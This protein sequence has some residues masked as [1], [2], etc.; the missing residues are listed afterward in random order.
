[1]RTGIAALLAVLLAPA[2]GG[3]L[4]AEPA[5]AA[6]KDDLTFARALVERGWT[7]VAEPVIERGLAGG[8]AEKERFRVLQADLLLK[9]ARRIGG[10]Q[11]RAEAFKRAFVVLDDLL[12]G[13]GKDPGPAG[14]ELGEF[15]VTSCSTV[16]EEARKETEAARAAE[17]KK[18][19]V[20]MVD[21]ASAIFTARLEAAQKSGGAPAK[22]G[23]D[24]EDEQGA[25]SA[26]RE[27]MDAAF[28]AARVEYERGLV[29]D[30]KVEREA[31]LRGAIRKLEDF[32]ASYADTLQAYQSAN[33]VGQCWNELGDFRKAAQ[34]FEGAASLAEQFKDGS[35]Q[36]HVNH[37]V[38]AEIIQRALYFKAQASNRAGKP[39]DARAAVDRAIRLFPEVRKRPIGLALRIEGGQAFAKQAK[40]REAE[41]ALR[42]V[43]QDDPEGP[44]GAQARER[45]GDLI[46]K[47]DSRMEGDL[48]PIIEG[49]FQK[50]EVAR[51]IRILRQ[52]LARFDL[53]GSLDAAAKRDL[54]EKA[55][56]VLMW[57][58]KAYDKSERNREAALVFE[59]LMERYPA[60]KLAPEAAFQSVR[61]R[62]LANAAA[63]SKFDQERYEE[64]LKRLTD[65]YPRSPQA[66]AGQFLKA[67]EAMKAGKFDDAVRLYLAVP[68]TAGQYRDTALYQAGLAAW[69]RAVRTPSLKDAK[70]HYD[71]AEKILKDTL[72]ACTKEEPGQD[73]DRA[74]N[75]ARV[76]V[77]ARVK[78]ADIY[79]SSAIKRF[80]EALQVIDATQKEDSPDPDQVALLNQSRV[81]T[82]SALGRLDDAV[83]A[84]QALRQSHPSTRL[85]ASLCR[86][87]AMAYDNRAAE[88]H[89]AGGDG[90]KDYKPLLSK[91]LEFYA[92]AFDESRRLRAPFPAS[93]QVKTADRAL[94]IALEV[95]GLPEGK[96][97][98]TD[99]LGKPPPPREVWERAVKLLEEA[100]PKQRGSKGTDWLPL[101][102]LGRAY[103]FLGDWVKARAA[104]E[105]ALVWGELLASTGEAEPTPKQAALEK[106]PDLLDIFLDL[107]FAELI[108]AKKGGVGRARAIFD[109]GFDLAQRDTCPWWKCRYGFIASEIKDGNYDKADGLLRIAQNAP[110]WSGPRCGL[111]EQFDALAKELESKVLK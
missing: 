85:L 73:P 5:A 80:P 62:L 23:E 50:N 84:Y 21:A 82:L 83:Q 32:Q 17:L 35:G 33:L 51:A 16:A 49:L 58:G 78:L 19:A 98:F 69:S 93:T 13:A 96:D 52:A 77:A 29:L 74:Q 55:P 46:G 39:A 64:D 22:A 63:S 27:E 36:P 104:L 70:P 31:A 42:E 100:K 101:A 40:Y 54:A 3:G 6:R 76:R 18:R 20:K 25:G 94:A 37:P 1:V 34:A 92:A 91:A 111:K 57:L 53:Q 110:E 38:A 72:A 59:E 75:R 11:P 108:P 2:A 60:H 61:S 89:K 107:G 99:L 9:A 106:A 15:L 95:T 44:G 71:R 4:A 41:A 45:L 47:G 97:S 30:D 81:R 103:G 10:A 26:S 14:V 90:Q 86:E 109:K 28:N 66:A 88:V 43:V 102:K 65:K 56:P 12:A 8:G 105:E 87:V 48:G 68:E 67:E 7:V 24:S 79:S